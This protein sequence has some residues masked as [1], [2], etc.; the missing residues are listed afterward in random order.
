MRPLNY[1]IWLPTDWP[2]MMIDAAINYNIANGITIAER[3]ARY[4]D[5]YCFGA[6]AK[7]FSIVNNFYLVNLDLL[8]NYGHYFKEKAN[9]LIDHF[10]KDKIILSNTIE[11]DDSA[12]TNQFYL[13]NLSNRQLQCANLLLEG[14]TVKEI[15]AYLNLSPRTIETYIDH[16]KHKL[17]CHTKTDLIVK[18]TKLKLVN[19]SLNNLT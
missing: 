7:K 19:Q 2:E 5:Y 10:E 8:Q 9:L 17:N 14:N 6:D 13:S 4:V 11:I 16:L 18:L 1:F 15:A 12:L 3:N